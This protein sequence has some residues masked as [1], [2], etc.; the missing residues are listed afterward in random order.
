MQ[1]Q[2]DNHQYS[3]SK[4]E[5]E[6]LYFLVRGHTAKMISKNLSISPRTV[7]QHLENI[8]RKIGVYSKACLID[9]IFE[10]FKDCLE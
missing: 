9:R 6:V 2:S 8:K 1:A 7:E 10:R 3:I 5:K 4:R